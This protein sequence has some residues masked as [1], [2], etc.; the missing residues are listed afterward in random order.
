MI[1]LVWP[2]QKIKKIFYNNSDIIFID[3]EG[4]W[5]YSKD[6]SKRVL[7]KNKKQNV[8]KITFDVP[9]ARNYL[10]WWMPLWT[11]WVPNA[12]KYEQIRDQLLISICNI[13]IML[14]YYKINCVIFNTSVP[15][16]LDTVIISIAARLNQIKQ[17]YLY[18]QV[19][20]GRLLPIL[21]T[22]AM[23]P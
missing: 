13:F 8:S 14:N 4:F 10:N 15:H 9:N 16:H 3:H 23:D 5:V 19:I 20:N 11:R 2:S 12:D 18:A 22:G 17:I 6:T 21:Q 7:L 1:A